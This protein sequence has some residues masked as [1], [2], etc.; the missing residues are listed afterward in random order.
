[1][2][3]R[4]LLLVAACSGSK[5]KSVEDARIPQASAPRDAPA[6]HDAAARAQ[7]GGK[8]DVQIR[9]E[10]KDVPLAAR[11]SPGR[12]SCGVAIAPAVAPTTMWGIPDAVVELE[13]APV[14]TAPNRIVLADCALSPRVVTATKLAIASAALE[15]AKL[16]LQEIGKLPLGG[17]AVAGGKARDVYLP[18]AGHEVEVALD[19][20]AIYSLADATIVAGDTLAVTDATGTAVVRGV[21]SGTHAITA[22]LPARSG[23]PARVAH[24]KVT[25][26]AGALAEVTLDL[27]K[28]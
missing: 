16:R 12:T 11:A 8:G 4:A 9:V 1:M 2:E 26:T 5:G 25:V 22:W 23:Q 10:W 21:P 13:G 17:A 27:A 28:P 14:A 15:P 19:A 6:P 7:P 3:L 24:G 20:G 18:I